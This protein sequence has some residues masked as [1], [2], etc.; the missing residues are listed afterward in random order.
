M[1]KQFLLLLIPF[2]LLAESS[3]ISTIPLPTTYIQLIDID[4]ECDSKCMQA[5]LDD[6]QIFTF[7]ALADDKLECMELEDERMIYVGLFNIGSTNFVEEELRIAMILPY[8]LIGRY[9]YSTS[10]AVFAYL[11]T[12]NHPFVL[13]NFQIDDESPEEME[14]VLDEIKEEEFHYVIAPLTAKGAQVIVDY[15][16]ELN[17]FFP[18]INKNDL[19]TS[20]EN[21]YFGAIDYKAQIEKLEARASSP[22]VVMYDKSAKGKKLYKQTKETYMESELPFQKTSRKKVFKELDEKY[23]TRLEPKKK[24]VIAY[25]IGRKT[26]NLKWHL[27]NNKKI[28]FGSFF[29]NTPVIKST[30]ILS[31]FTT[32]DTNVTNILST[33]INYD[34]LMFS[35]TQKQD[36]DNMYIAN[37]VNINNNTLI[38][39]NS[40]LSNDIV[41]DW[42][43]YATTVG[44]DYFYHV[45]T[46]AERT[47]QLPMLDNQVLYPI[48][49]VKPSGSRFE[50]VE[51]GVTPVL[52]EYGN[53]VIPT[54][55]QL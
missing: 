44:A 25:G 12:R 20:A 8:K 34:P 55:E 53:V 32:Y 54:A 41:Y 17:V 51:E 40:L 31:Q 3:Q 14:R 52:D 1:I 30:M 10:N 6:G 15:E 39:A 50:V 21:I 4:E 11:L 43:N 38:Q 45:I 33:Q 13:K 19:N 28:Q 7:L 2:F 48:S 47:Y 27:E 9:A 42:I 22:L 29:L 36:R 16:E 18:T 46:N 26:T 49:I 23:S 35:M 5:Y 24:R 37:S